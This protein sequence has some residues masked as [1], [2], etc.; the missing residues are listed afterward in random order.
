MLEASSCLHLCST[1]QP[2]KLLHLIFISSYSHY[3]FSSLSLSL[4]TLQSTAM[5]LQFSPHL[6]A[7]ATWAANECN[8]HFKYP[9]TT[10]FSLCSIKLQDFD[11]TKLKTFECVIDLSGEKSRLDR[12]ADSSY[13]KILGK[14][15]LCCLSPFSRKFSVRITFTNS[16][17]LPYFLVAYSRRQLHSNSQNI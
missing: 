1:L 17:T 9:F 4:L 16:M 11:C 14:T 2:R 5:K 8:L 6:T 3:T 10:I 12:V 7:R 15:F 13:A